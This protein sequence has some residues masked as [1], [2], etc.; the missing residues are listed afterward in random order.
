MYLYLA[1]EDGFDDLPEPLKT[2]FGTPKLVI[3]LEL[4]NDRPLARV[5]VRDTM[6]AL[7]ENG[8]FLQ[9]PPKL[10]PE[11]NYGE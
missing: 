5:D 8:Y 9:L 11:M 1:K 6:T 2:G 3:S 10:E 7:K 4:S